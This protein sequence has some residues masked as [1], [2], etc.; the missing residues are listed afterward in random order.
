MPKLQV[1]SC[2]SCGASLGFEEGEATAQCQFCGNTVMIPEEL[3][4]AQPGAQPAPAAS[5]VR[6]GG[7]PL[8]DQL[9]KLREMG[10]LVRAGR[11]DEAAQIYRQLFGGTESEARGAV[12]L[13]AAGQPVTVHH[14][15][16]SFGASTDASGIFRFD[17]SGMPQIQV[18]APSLGASAPRVVTGTPMAVS[19]AYTGAYTGAPVVVRSG[20]GSPLAG[21]I[22]TLV[23]LSIIGTVAIAAFGVLGGLAPLLAIP[24]IGDVIG[25]VTN[26]YPRV[27]LEFGGAGTGA[28]YFTDARH[29][30][31]D[32]AGN[33]Y[34]GE[35]TGGRVQVFN[36]E[37]A[38]QAQWIPPADRD[39][40]LSGL[41]VDRDGDVYLVY[42]SELFRFDGLTGEEVQHYDYTDGW[43][44]TDVAVLPN[45]GVVAGWYKNR[46]DLI[47]Y[48]RN[49]DE[50]L[51]V[52]NI[53]STVT[54]K[55]ASSPRVAVNGRGEV[56]MTA[57]FDDAVF[58]FSADGRYQ[59]R[60]GSG[61]GDEFRLLG[62]IA[63]DNQGRV[64]VADLSGI[65]VFEADGRYLSTIQTPTRAYA[66]GLAIDQHNNLYV[67][68]NDRVYKYQLAADE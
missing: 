8:L 22:I 27:V 26:Q 63:I 64:Y 34:V 55:S 14:V 50:T 36:P 47:F 54:G 6:V 59:N 10:D 43:G 16:S 30:G 37:G 68:S 56:Y 25:R 62:D 38:F 28:G 45:G 2:P 21:C 49:G 11:R 65:Q 58:R 67:V 51:A 13:M 1:L 44:F 23:V 35:Y 60:F 33:I 57:T 61:S 9:P 32:A 31:V 18:G 7:V 12:D 40:Y 52:Q 19:G 20:G 42:G 5:G 15:S 17:R 53:I 4:R 29:V 3:R 48:D 24:G 66:Y 41:A 46:D 39:I